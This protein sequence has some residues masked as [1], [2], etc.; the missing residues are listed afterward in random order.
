MEGIYRALK[1]SV[2]GGRNQVWGV[3]EG[4]PEE[5]ILQ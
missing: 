3:Q 5:V 1:E 2:I 4:F